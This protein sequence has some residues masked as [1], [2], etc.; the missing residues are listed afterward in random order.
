MAGDDDQ[1]IYHWKGCDIRIFQKWSC[2]QKIILPH[3]HRL[4]K[5]IYKLAHNTIE[6]KDYEVMIDFLKRRRYL[7]QAKVTRKFE[8]KFSY[9]LGSNESIFINSGS[10]ANLL[11][12]QTL[13]RLPVNFYKAL[14]I[15]L[16]ILSIYP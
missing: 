9:F 15:Y 14:K 5:K 11:I 4:P 8:K 1:A 3:T 12:A 6:N 7:N 2:R 16:S 13:I 10:S